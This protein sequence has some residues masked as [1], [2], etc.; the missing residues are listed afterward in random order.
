MTIDIRNVRKGDHVTIRAEV[1]LFVDPNDTS[2]YVTVD[3]QNFT[4]EPRDI[5]AHE[6]NFAVGE[7]VFDLDDNSRVGEILKVRG[8]TAIVL[9]DGG[10]NGRGDV[11]D[12]C[13]LTLLA[14]LKPEED[15]AVKR[16]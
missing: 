12:N 6:P 7:R 13:H 2:L 8:N 15:P 4:V 11:E 9:W 16:F 14:P 5:V 10:V 3:H 1:T